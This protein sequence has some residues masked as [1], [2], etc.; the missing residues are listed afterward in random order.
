MDFLESLRSSLL[1]V[2]EWRKVQIASAHVENCLEEN[3]CQPA[4]RRKLIG[5]CCWRSLGFGL[6]TFLFD[7]VFAVWRVVAFGEWSN[8]KFT[9]VILFISVNAS[10]CK[11]AAL[12][13]WR[14]TK[15]KFRVK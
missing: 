13:F 2:A 8:K 15:N 6:W 11:L 9:F 12:F 10:L 14:V 3:R 5:G 7:A 1:A 4:W